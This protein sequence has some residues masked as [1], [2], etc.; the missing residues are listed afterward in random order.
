MGGDGAQLMLLGSKEGYE[1]TKRLDGS[2]YGGGA[3]IYRRCF[4][5]SLEAIKKY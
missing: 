1:G 3:P 5:M 2:L 4:E